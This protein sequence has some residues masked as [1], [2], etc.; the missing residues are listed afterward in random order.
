MFDLNYRNVVRISLPSKAINTRRLPL[1]SFMYSSV[2]A[3][4]SK[5][6]LPDAEQRVLHVNLETRGAPA[7]DLSDLLLLVKDVCACKS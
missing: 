4:I 7:G 3:N 5:H 2:S 1:L 6:V